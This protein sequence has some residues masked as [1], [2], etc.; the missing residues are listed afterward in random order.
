MGAVMV[1]LPSIVFLRQ[2]APNL[3]NFVLSVHF[4]ETSNQNMYNYL[5]ETDP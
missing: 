4:S 3:P 5:K 1:A 2:T